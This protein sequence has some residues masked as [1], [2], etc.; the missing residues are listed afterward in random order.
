M[1]HEA[2]RAVIFDLDGVLVDSEPNY[3]ES[4]RILLGRHGITFTAEMKVPYIGMSTKEML[5]HVKNEFGLTTALVTLLEEKNA[6]YLQ[7]A[8]EHTQVNAPMRDLVQLLREHGYPLALASGSSPAAID[9]VLSH[10]G[11]GAA[12]DVVVSAEAVRRGKPEPDLFLAAATRLGVQPAACVVI[13]DSGYGVTAARRAGM[14]CIAIPYGDTLAMGGAFAE[15]DLLLSGP[16]ANIDA[17]SILG[18][19]RSD[20]TARPHRP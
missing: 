1:P 11:L 4:E 7:L 6:I 5:E 16:M 18:W 19:I 8:A 10:A 14:R 17:L 15:A 20:A 9:V 13:E 2:I 3:L 12:F